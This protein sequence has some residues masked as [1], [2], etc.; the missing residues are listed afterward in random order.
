MRNKY[1]PPIVEKPILPDIK[2]PVSLP[3]VEPMQF[4]CIACCGRANILFEGTTYC[5]SCLKEKLRTGN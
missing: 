4:E 3:S 5:R 2:L 1:M